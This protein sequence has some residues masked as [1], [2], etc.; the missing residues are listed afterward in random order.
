MS[1]MF[2]GV[3]L[4]LSLSSPAL[5]AGGRAAVHPSREAARSRVETAGPGE[6]EPGGTVFVP[7]RYAKRVLGASEIHES[8]RRY[9]SKRLGLHPGEVELRAVR[10]LAGPVLLPDG[11]FQISVE[12][13]ANTRFIGQTPLLL[14][15]MRRGREVKRFWVKAEIAVLSDVPV[16][17]RPVRIGQRLV[18]AMFEVRRRNVA[19]LP[20]DV[21]TNPAELNG[22]YAVRAMTPGDVVRSSDVKFPYVVRQGRLVR[23]VARHGKLSIQAVGKVMDQGRKGDVV[24]IL[25][26]DSNKI[27]QGRVLD[28]ATVEVLF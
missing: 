6:G 17:D 27:V 1:R 19:V 16:L 26:I 21:V 24:R 14:R 15:V 2:M 11:P 7:V 25:N 12:A 4:V 8:V 3:C 20:R 13:P 18:P 10:A 23:I 22:A 9:L 5:A 28:R